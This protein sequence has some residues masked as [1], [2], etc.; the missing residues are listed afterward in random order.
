MW[1]FDSPLSQKTPPELRDMRFL[2]LLAFFLCSCS[3]NAEVLYERSFH[4]MGSKVELKFYSP[5]EQLFLAVTEASRKRMEEIDRLF[6]NYRDDSV[7]AEVNRYAGVRPVTVPPE[8]IRLTRLSTGYSELTDGAF[9]VTVGGLYELWKEKTSSGTIPSPA[10]IKR[11]LECSGYRKI[12]TDAERSRIFFESDC[13]RLDFGAVGKGY[14]VD[15]IMAVARKNGITRGL[16][17]F[18]GSVFAMGSPDGARSWDVRVSGPGGV[19][20]SS[21]ELRDRGAATSGGY[22]RY[23]EHGGRRYSHVIDPRTGRPAENV[24]LVTAISKTAAGADVFSTAV[25]VLGAEAARAFAESDEFLGFVVVERNGEKKSY[26]GASLFP[27][28]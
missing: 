8:F 16:V 10:E 24:A 26:F 21:L 3:R 14:A 7:L 27:K 15:E 25:S 20:V 5:N 2:L 23:F 9:D 13:L 18:G 19:F 11:A 6:S 4:V 22:E 12:G 28:R 17:N 1:G